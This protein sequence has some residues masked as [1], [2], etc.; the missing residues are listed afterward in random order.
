MSAKELQAKLNDSS[1][2]ATLVNLWATWCSPCTE[3]L[4]DLVKLYKRRGKEGFRLILISADSTGDL[5]EAS[6]L[7]AKVGVDF[8]TYR[9][10]EPPDKFIATF[11]KN[12]SATLPTS[13]LTNAKGAQIRTWVGRVPMK[14]LEKRLSQ[15]VSNRPGSGDKGALAHPGKIGSH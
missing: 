3:E 7:L 14:E 6:A 13:L 4:P 10:A 2:R 12:W 8:E 5:K 15:P 9:L 1:A 11:I